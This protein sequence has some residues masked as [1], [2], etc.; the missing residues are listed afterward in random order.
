MK[1]NSLK[2]YQNRIS[3]AS[4]ET[5]LLYSSDIYRNRHKSISILNDTVSICIALF[6]HVS[7]MG[8]S[9]LFYFDVVVY[10]FVLIIDVPPSCFDN[11]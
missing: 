5:G 2:L 3:R 10:F 6:Q 1:R 11:S 7:M 4:I 8:I 9:L